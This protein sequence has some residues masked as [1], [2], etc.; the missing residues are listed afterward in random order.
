MMQ[1][2]LWG[3]TYLI[4]YKIGTFTPDKNSVDLD[5]MLQNAASDQGL[6]CLSLIRQCFLN[7]STG[8]KLVLFKS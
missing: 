1:I 4:S 5:Q 2:K 6:H 7:T 3:C 8:S